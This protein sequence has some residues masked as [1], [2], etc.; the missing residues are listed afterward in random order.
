MKPVAR[1]FFLTRATYR[2]DSSLSL[3]VGNAMYLRNGAAKAAIDVTSVFVWVVVR[4]QALWVEHK[5]EAYWKRTTL[6][7]L[8][9]SRHVGL[10]LQ[11]SRDHCVWGIGHQEESQ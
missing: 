6:L 4:S 3:I 1:P 5:L 9:P 10:V 8:L 2:A 7:L 11:D